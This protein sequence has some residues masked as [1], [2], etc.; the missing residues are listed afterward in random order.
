MD[1]DKPIATK[2][3]DNIIYVGDIN[4][5]TGKPIM[6]YLSAVMYAFNRGE[7]EVVI[8]ARGKYINNAVSVADM[9]ERNPQNNLQI[10]EKDGFHAIK[11]GSEIYHRPENKE[12]NITARD[13]NVSFI[14]IVIVKK[15]Q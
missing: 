4:P 14:E 13:M 7:T 10:K 6:N 15:S 3:N 11:I 8:K 2:K 9:S 1:N 12:K 5:K